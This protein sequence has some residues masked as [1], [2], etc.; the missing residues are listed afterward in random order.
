MKQFYD[1]IRE[2]EKKLTL[3]QEADLFKQIATGNTQARDTIFFSNLRFSIH[4]AKKYYVFGSI[5][6]PDLIQ[7]CSIGLY[8]SIDTF[9]YRVGVKF[10]TYARWQIHKEVTEY[11]QS[12]LRTIRLPAN[13][14]EH[15]K[16]PTSFSMDAEKQDDDNDF[17]SKLFFLESEDK[18]EISETNMAIDMIT[19][20]LK[21]FEITLIKERIFNEKTFV[22]ISKILKEKHNISV[23][24]TTIATTYSR[25]MKKLSKKYTKEKFIELFI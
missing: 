4:F 6:E 12:N 19:D 2:K 14:K 24:R 5:H 16:Y 21:P 13:M 23:S 8:N 18:V 15:I 3:E 10:I 11:L 17:S 20:N 25:L 7:V 9:D 1:E 22:E